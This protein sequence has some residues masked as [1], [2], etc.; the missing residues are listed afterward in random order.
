VRQRLI[1]GFLFVFLIGCSAHSAAPMPMSPQ[2]APQFQTLHPLSIVSSTG[3]ISVNPRHDSRIVSYDSC[4][5]RGQIEY[6]SD[7]FNNVINIYDGKFAGQRPCGQ[8][9]SGSGLYIPEGLFVKSCAH[10]LYVANFTQVSVFHRGQT[11]PY[12]TYSDPSN[13]VVQDVTVAEDGTVIASNLEPSESNTGGSISTWIAGPNGGTFVGNFP[14]T[15]VY[16]GGFI[17]DQV[18][19]T[20]YFNDVDDTTGKGD[21]WFVSCPAGACGTQ[22][23][24][25]GVSF[26]APGG[27]AFD[28]TDT[29]LATDTYALTGDRFKLPNPVPKTFKMVGLLGLP[30]GM[31]FSRPD[32]HWFVAD[33]N[34]ANSKAGATEYLFPSGELVGTVPGNDHGEMVGIAV[35]H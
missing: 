8:I 13:Q 24:V 35:D 22:T 31:A 12:N 15:N 5:S 14:M 17:A 1:F 21:L 27:M 10:D 6:V 29:L 2:V 28:G 33:A 7:A 26:K 9:A 4:P 32:R 19:E 3:R 30:V 20:V 11:T 25:T 16:K 34:D 23:Q 18:G